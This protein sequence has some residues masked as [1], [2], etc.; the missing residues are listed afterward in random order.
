MFL[1]H[2][3]HL[4]N[5]IMWLF[6]IFGIFMPQVSMYWLVPIYTKLG[7]LGKKHTRLILVVIGVALLFSGVMVELFLKSPIRK[8]YILMIYF[9]LFPPINMFK[10]KVKPS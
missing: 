1:D 9:L 4:L 6:L 5:T 3:D 10:I 7:I 8:V 2:A